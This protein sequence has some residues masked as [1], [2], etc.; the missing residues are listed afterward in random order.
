MD[1]VLGLSVLT[2]SYTQYKEATCRES[3]SLI[4]YARRRIGGYTPQLRDDTTA[5]QGSWSTSSTSI[6]PLPPLSDIHI[7]GNSTDDDV[8]VVFYTSYNTVP[9]H[10]VLNASDLRSFEG[11][12]LSFLAVIPLSNGSAVLNRTSTSQLLTNINLLKGLAEPT[13]VFVDQDINNG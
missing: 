9:V 7:D 5:S 13:S 12:S 6:L 4:K 2:L 11:G 3:S 10:T 1:R 8:D